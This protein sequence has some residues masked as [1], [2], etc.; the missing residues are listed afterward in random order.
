MRRKLARIYILRAAVFLGSLAIASAFMSGCGKGFDKGYP[1][2]IS[3]AN[4]TVRVSQSSVEDAVHDDRVADEVLGERRAGWRRQGWHDRQ[5]GDVY[6]AGTYTYA[7]QCRDDHEPC[8]EFSAGHARIVTVNVLNPIPVIKAVTPSSFS[9]G[10]MTV[11][12]K[13]SQF[14]Y[15]AQIFWNGVPVPTTYVSGTQLAASI[16]APNPGTFPLM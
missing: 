3:A 14:L 11:T 2:Y 1:S 5:Q 15:G 9:E 8:D 10:T 7:K 16:S 13:G 12:V 4:T 6:R